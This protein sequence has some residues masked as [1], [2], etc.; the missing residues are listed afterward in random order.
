MDDY[1]SLHDHTKEE[2]IAVYAACWIVLNP[3][4]L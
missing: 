1:S 4:A 2:Q 3:V